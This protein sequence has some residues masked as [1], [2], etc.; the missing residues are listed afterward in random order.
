M[1]DKNC[2]RLL[3]N[4]EQIPNAEL[5]EKI[6]SKQLLQTYKEIERII[7]DFGLLTE[8]RYYKDG[9]SWLCKVTHKK[10]TIVWVSLWENFFKSG[11]YFTEKNRNGIESLN[12]D[13]KI[14][15]LFSKEKPIGK[16]IPL[17][18]DIQNVAELENFKKIIEYKLL[19]K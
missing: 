10:K 3:Q 6:L 18:L 9:K 13:T 12:I 7:S 16:L 11:F 2:K 5:F 14:K 19:L 4:P 8:W 1:E 17:I 15:T